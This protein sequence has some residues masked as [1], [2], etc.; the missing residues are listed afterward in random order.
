MLERVGIFD[1][2]MR[3]VRDFAFNSHAQRHR[4]NGETFTH[5]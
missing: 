3:N 4:V 2:C 1:P 5:G